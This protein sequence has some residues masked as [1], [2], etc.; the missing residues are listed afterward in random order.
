MEV[1][2]CLKRSSPEFAPLADYIQGPKPPDQVYSA[3]LHQA[4]EY[5]SLSKEHLIIGFENILSTGQKD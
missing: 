4:K 3:K 2:R 1:Y 5:V